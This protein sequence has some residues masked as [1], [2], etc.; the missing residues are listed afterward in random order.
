M[1]RFKD[2]PVTPGPGTYDVPEPGSAPCNAGVGKA[3]AR[4]KGARFY[5]IKS[6]PG[7]GFYTARS[8]FGEFTAPS[9]GKVWQVASRYLDIVT[10]KVTESKKKRKVKKR[11]KKKRRRPEKAT[12]SSVRKFGQVRDKLFLIQ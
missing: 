6:S 10:K 11:R 9:G 8:Q 7:P 3:R 1:G 5:K 4:I 12:F 2:I